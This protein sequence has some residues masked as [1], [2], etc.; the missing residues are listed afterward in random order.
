MPPQLTTTALGLS[1]S[2]TASTV[3]NLFLPN[4]NLPGSW[5]IKTNKKRV[6]RGLSLRCNAVAKQ[7]TQDKK[8]FLHK[9]LTAVK[10]HGFVSGDAEGLAPRVK[11]IRSMLSSMEDGEISISAYDTAW[12]A[13]VEDLNGTGRP[14]FP[15]SLE[16]IARNQLPD[17]S[18]GDASIFLSHDRII[19]TF[20]CLI[21]LKYWKLH[22]DKQDKG[23]AFIKGNICKIGEEDDE[24]MPVGFEVTFPS[25]IEKARNLG[26]EVPDECRPVLDEIY[27]K[28]R[29]KLT[30]LEGMTGLDWER[31]LKLQSQDG[32]FLF[33]PAST[34]YALA[35]SRDL[36]CLRYLE[37]TL[38]RFKGVPNVYPVDLF[39][40]IWAIDRLQR[41]GIC[42]YFKHE[43]KECIKYVYRYWTERGICW[44]RNSEFQS[45][46][47]TAMGFRLLRLH[48]H[49]VSAD[50]FEN[51]KKDGEFLCLA[52]QSTQSVTVMYNLYRASQLQFPGEEVLEEARS[53]SSKYLR[54]KQSSNQLLDKW[55]IAKDLAGEVK[56]ALD[57]PWHGNLS[58]IET[59]F[60]IEQ[61]GGD[62][63]AW[64]GKTLYR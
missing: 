48:G 47:E 18:W 52:G 13:L 58:R 28:R 43:I 54:Q 60:Y 56:Y 55:M 17:G 29:I 24:H 8:E 42:R 22:A 36:N 63:D 25:L 21:A 15:E 33:S 26:M 19:S 12:V 50:V 30:S 3:K 53:F 37:N 57:I 64:I 20:A 16:W 4:G 35:Q 61:Y 44:A 32:S 9:D 14:Q 34:A 7:S 31:L 62:S 41:L 46:D 10:R 1:H 11:T 2:P 51:F 6:G 23:M 40:R 5:L 38:K 27:S 39:E 45:M 59:R 49:Q